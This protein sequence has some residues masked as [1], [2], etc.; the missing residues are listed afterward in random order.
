VDN[1][2][3]ICEDDQGVKVFDRSEHEQVGD[4]LL[5]HQTGFQAYDI[6][7][8]GGKNLAMVIGED[9]LYQFDISD[10]SKMNQLSVIP[11]I[12]D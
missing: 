6:I 9:G 1:S 12:R 8:L 3:Y 4:K 7:A 2:L 11:V 5:T 10:R